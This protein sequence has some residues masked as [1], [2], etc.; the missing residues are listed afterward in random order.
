MAAEDELL[1]DNFDSGSEDSLD[2]LVGVVFVMPREFDW[3]TEVDDN[4][5]SPKGKCPP[6]NQSVTI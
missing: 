1:T 4:D 2:I 6:S 5:I 3:I